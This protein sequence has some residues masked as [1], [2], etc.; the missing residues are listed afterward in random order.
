[1]LKEYKSLQ[2]A[3]DCQSSSQKLSRAVRSMAVS[4]VIFRNVVWTKFLNAS[5]KVRRRK[6][7][8]YEDLEEK[9]EMWQEGQEFE[10]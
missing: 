5:D 1:M 9:M 6:V 8:R 4:C 2:K 10:G 7:H 3:Q